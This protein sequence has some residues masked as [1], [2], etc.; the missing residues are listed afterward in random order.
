MKILVLR[1]PSNNSWTLS[2]F[3]FDNVQFGFG[4]EDR[5]RDIKIQGETA[6]PDGI[7]SM[8]LHYPSK[9]SK[10]YY[11]SDNGSLLSSKLIKFESQ[12]KQFHTP[13]EMIHVLN[14]PGFEYVLWHWG[15]TDEDTEGCYIVGSEYANFN[16]KKGVSGSRKKYEDIYPR[17]WSE[18]KKGTVT[19]EYKTIL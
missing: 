1:S 5:N 9:F 16:G 11:R 7:Y 13:H 10:F 18:I 6:I 17:I 4:V 12:K 8:G 14:V 3:Y 2:R 19:V 15:N